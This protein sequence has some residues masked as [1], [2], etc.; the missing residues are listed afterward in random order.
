MVKSYQYS[1]AIMLEDFRTFASL[2][3]TWF[4]FIFSRELEKTGFVRILSIIWRHTIQYYRK[5]PRNAPNIHV[6]WMKTV[7]GCKLMV[8]FIVR[9][10]LSEFDRNHCICFG[11]KCAGIIRWLVQVRLSLAYWRLISLYLY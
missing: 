2:S 8:S 11:N 5:L 4:F 6:L 1:S 9:S 10:T 3:P 7:K